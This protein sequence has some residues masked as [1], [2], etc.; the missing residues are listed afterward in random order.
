M[1]HPPK[2]LRFDTP[3]A[4][5]KHRRDIGLHSVASH[6]MPPGNISVMTADERAV[7]ARWLAENR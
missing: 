1:G 3:D 5:L 7:L 6:A 4:I 2:N